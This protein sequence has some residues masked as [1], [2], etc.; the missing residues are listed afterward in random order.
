MSF[1]EAEHVFAGI[2][3]DALNDL[4][5]A[6]FGARPR[7]LRYGSTNFVPVTTV[8]A[9]HMDSIPFPGIPGGID[10]AVTLDVPIIDLYDQDRPL[11]PELKLDPGQLSISTSVKL[12]LGCRH[13]GLDP[14]PDN[15]DRKPDDDQ[16]RNFDI[17]QTCCRLKI[18]AIGHLAE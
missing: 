1:T 15:H 3:E 2:H 10:W 18:F 8:S 9:T 17:H 14:E 16:R 12:C 11:P 13:E 4:I 5:R 7:H 6:F